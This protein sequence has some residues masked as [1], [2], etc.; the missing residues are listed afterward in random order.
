M[1]DTYIIHLRGVTWP[2]STLR[3]WEEG[4]ETSST[5]TAFVVDPAARLLLTTAG[6]VE[7]AKKVLNTAYIDH[8]HELHAALA[9]DALVTVIRSAVRC[10]RMFARPACTHAHMRMHFIACSWNAGRFKMSAQTQCSM[11]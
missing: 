5:S 1:Y 6:A 4:I 2:V 8:L 7:H 9:Q 11:Y 10:L 3:P